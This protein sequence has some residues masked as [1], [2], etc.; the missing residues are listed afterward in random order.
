MENNAFILTGTSQTYYTTSENS[1]LSETSSTLA[2]DLFENPQSLFADILLPTELAKLAKQAQ[3][4]FSNHHAFTTKQ[5]YTRDWFGFQSWC[6][7]YGLCALPADMS[8]V[9]LYITWMA[10]SHRA[11]STITQHLA[12]IKAVH[13]NK[14][15]ISP[16]HSTVITTILRGIRRQFGSLSHGVE[17]ILPEML[18]QLLATIDDTTLIGKRDRTILLLGFAGAFRRSEIVGI[19][20][21]DLNWRDEGVVI[22]L[23]QSKT[24]QTGHGRLVGIPRGKH[25]EFCPVLALETWLS[26]SGIKDAAIFR[27]MDCYDRIVSPRLSGRA[28]AQIIKR[29]AIAAGLDPSRYSGHSLRA[30]HCTAA[31]RA[32]VSEKLIMQ[33]TGHKSHQ[34]M[35]KYIRLGK[36][37]TENSARIINL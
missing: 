35:L 12:A 13:E 23:R 30:G 14:G 16:T 1:H 20:I 25:P 3:T 21:N 2:Q 18:H 15:Y 37:L 33:Q 8:T 34:T 10:Q 32:G 11:L 36:I 31:A 28:I 26:A 19:N 24:D 5:A 27:G 17:A 4:Y 9:S 6:K 29:R 22:L 7:N